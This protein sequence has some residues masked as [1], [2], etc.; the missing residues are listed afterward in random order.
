M[1]F[2][3]NKV[4]KIF[5]GIG[6]LCLSDVV[7]HELSNHTNISAQSGPLYG[8]WAK[9]D[10]KSRYFVSAKSRDPEYVEQ[11]SKVE[12]NGHES[13]LGLK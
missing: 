11:I 12:K 10:E 13:L 8:V 5:L 2:F 1:A 6:F 7:F 9:R 3:R 4:L